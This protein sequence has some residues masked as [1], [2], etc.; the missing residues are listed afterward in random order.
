[1][2]A[3]ARKA[4]QKDRD[5]ILPMVKKINYNSLSELQQ[6]DLLRAIEIILA[7]MG[8]PGVQERNDLISYLNVNYPHKASNDVNRQLSKLLI[9]LEAPDAVAKTMNLMANARDIENEEDKNF[10]NSADLIMR[11]P[12]YGMD[13]ASTLSKLPPLQQTYLA[14]VLS[15]AKKGW[16]PD[17]Q[18]QYFKWFYNAFSYKGGYS[19]RGFINLA[20]K[21]ALSNVSKDK[22]AYFNSISGDSIAD[23]PAASLVEGA[24]R[25]K[26]PGR[27]WSVDEA[28]KYV[29]S[30]IT[31]RNF[32]KGKGLF[33]SSLCAACHTMNDMGGVS[34]PNLTQLGTR[35]SYRNML[36]AIIEPSKT[37]SDQYGATVFFMN[38]GN[39]VLGRLVSEDKDS[40]QV[41]QNP[42]APQ[43]L[44]EISKKNVSRI[45]VSEVSPMLPSM[46]NNLNPEELKDLLAYLKSGGNRQDTIFRQTKTTSGK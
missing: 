25:P 29:D 31:A 36:E 39:S 46:I 1:M 11:N 41:S 10:I 18:E 4:D 44:R 28:M 19:F 27:N 22:F 43:Q 23:K 33:I 5:I 16:T 6:F 35:F 20:R 9:F 17:L 14:T 42:F 7:R 12:Q 26:G 45:M 40:Y 24:I 38:D 15:Q 34:G 37:I 2:I 8:T 21:Q 3:L 32:E 30:G 13:I